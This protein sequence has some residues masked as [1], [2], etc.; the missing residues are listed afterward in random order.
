M[1]HSKNRKVG[2]LFFTLNPRSFPLVRKPPFIPRALA[3]IDLNVDIQEATHG[4]GVG[5]RV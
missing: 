5:L 2:L 4:E 3:Q 1:T